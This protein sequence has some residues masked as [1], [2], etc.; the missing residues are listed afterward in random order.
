[1][2]NGILNLQKY[3]YNKILT[4]IKS[5][6]RNY[7]KSLR[8]YIAMLYAKPYMKIYLENEIVNTKLFIYSL[9]KPCEFTITTGNLK[10]NANQ[11]KKTIEVS[12]TKISDEIRTL[13]DEIM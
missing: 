1:V 4:R 11:N 3:F 5:N 8:Q 12:I 13:Q 6:E 7:P 10:S 2:H 9:L